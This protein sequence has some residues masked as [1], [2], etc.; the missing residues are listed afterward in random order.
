VSHWTPGQDVG[1]G[2]R[3]GQASGLSSRELLIVVLGD[4]WRTCREPIPSAALVAVLAEFGVSDANAR[5]ALSR[6]GRQGA[7]ERHRDGRRTAYR[8]TDAAIE[9][10]V[11]Y[12]RLLMRFGLDWPTW[13]GRWTA[14]GFTLTEDANR[15][16]QALRAGLRHLRMAQLYDGLWVS[17]HDV[18]VPLAAL[19][20]ELG[21]YSSTIFRAD[22]A[23]LDVK[24]RDPVEAWNLRALRTAYAQ[25]AADARRL[26]ARLGRRRVRAAE[27]LTARTTF[28]VRWRQFAWDDPLLPTELLPA[29]WPMLD[30]RAA[31]AEV[32]DRLG[33]VAEARVRA[34]VAPFDLP[35]EAQPR[36]HT[37]GDG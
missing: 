20:E 5:A 16:G 23:D 37:T 8:L 22:V 15:V 14:I 11:T 19:V 31:F 32:Y 29:D 13:D 34:V 2:A 12:G 36:H 33:P 24:G 17:A 25:F 18:T 1:G 9:R 10:S 35:D 28:T 4:F 6:L 7:L 30:A 21:V 27:C 3:A 26:T